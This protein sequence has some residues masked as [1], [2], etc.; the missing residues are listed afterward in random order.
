MS[1]VKDRLGAG[2]GVLLLAGC[3]MSPA[4]SHP[5]TPSADPV[6]EIE[7]E[8]AIAQV[9]CGGA[10]FPAALLDESGNAETLSD[11]AAE[12]LRRHLGQPGPD[13]AWLPDAGWRE[14][15]RTDSQVV[16]L[17]DAEPGGDSPYAEVTVQREGDRWSVGGWGQCRL[18]ADVGPD[19]GLATFRVDPAAVLDPAEAEIPVLVTEQ[20]CNSGGNALG[21]IVDPIIV[22]G[23]DAITVIF[24]VRPRGGGQDCQGNPETPYRLTLPEPLGERALLDSSAVPPRDATLCPDTGSCAP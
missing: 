11:P 1:A 19:L 4:G 2:I 5:E 8:R 21:R 14:V 22:L 13:F 23:N 18:Q 12:A 9:S 17:A 24:A 16:Y 10:G 7:P 15:V 6:A 20:A 3:G